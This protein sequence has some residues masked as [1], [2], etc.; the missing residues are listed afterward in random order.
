MVVI[1]DVGVPPFGGR[2]EVVR[3]RGDRDIYLQVAEHG[4]AV[5]RYSLHSGTMPG[6]GEEAGIVINETVVGAV[7]HGITR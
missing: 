3:D 5:Y 2:D 6:Y 4:G 7:G 1:V